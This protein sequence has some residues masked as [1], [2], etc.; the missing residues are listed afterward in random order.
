M[1][2]VTEIVVTLKTDDATYKEKFLCYD[3]VSFTLEDMA[4]KNCVEKAKESF[5]GEIKEIIVKATASYQ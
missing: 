5:K 3:A 4:L 1:I 2:L